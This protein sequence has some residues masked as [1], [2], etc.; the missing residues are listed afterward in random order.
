MNEWWVCSRNGELLRN[1]DSTWRQHEAHMKEGIGTLDSDRVN[2]KGQPLKGGDGVR[3]KI[4]TSS[5][6]VGLVMTVGATGAAVAAA[7]PAV[8]QPYCATA[9]SG[10][11]RTAK[12]ACQ[13]SAPL[14]VFRLVVT[15][16]GTSS[17]QQARGPWW[18][19]DNL[20]HGWR[21]SGFLASIDNI[22]F[23]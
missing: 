20:W 4:R 16:C 6:L 5:V 2:D 3:A 23:G 13:P 17:C 12:G 9:I 15:I 7:S 1:M 19:Q 8:A 14:N 18:P 10:D 21:P 22:E 11:G